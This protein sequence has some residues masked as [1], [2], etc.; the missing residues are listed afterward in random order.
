M[1]NLCFFILL[2]LLPIQLLALKPLKP[3]KLGVG[4]YLGVPSV[5]NPSL[6]ADYRDFSIRVSG[7][8]AGDEW[9]NG[10][11]CA[12][13]KP[14]VANHQLFILFGESQKKTSRQK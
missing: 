8:Y 14:L 2:I 4:A 11:A 5:I 3:E 6:Y 7:I 10:Y 13:F 9:I 12:L 1:K